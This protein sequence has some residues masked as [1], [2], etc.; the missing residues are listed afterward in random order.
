M[1]ETYIPCC[2]KQINANSITMTVDKFLVVINELN[3]E[4]EVDDKFKSVLPNGVFLVDENFKNYGNRPSAKAVSH[5]SGK[6]QVLD[7]SDVKE[8]ISL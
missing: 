6:I 3:G 7:E 4:L 8:F 2:L 1:S 5:Q